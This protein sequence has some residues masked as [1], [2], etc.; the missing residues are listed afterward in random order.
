MN[1][2]TQARI[3]S[4]AI[5]RRTFLSASTA[6]AAASAGAQQPAIPIIDTHIHF[7]DTT[8]PIGVPY[9]GRNAAPGLPVAIPE[10]FRRVAVPLGVVGAI[11]LEASPWIEDNLWVLELCRK[12]T[13]MLG[14]V[15]NLEPEK[16]EF[17]EYLARYHKD[18][19]FLGIR[20]GN[21]WGRNIVSQ[22]ENPEFVAGIK[23]LAAAGLTMDTA[24]PRPDLIRA[25]VRLTDKVPDLRVV[26]DHLPGLEP[27]AE[28]AS[29]RAF[30]T[31]L[32]ELAKRKVFVKVSV[33]ARLVDGKVPTDLAIYKPRLDL[34]WDIF[35]EDRL[36]YASDWPN[37]AGN[38][39]P[40]AT[41]LALVR[42]FFMGKGRGAAEK[43]FWKNSIA[44][45]KWVRRAANQPRLP[46][47]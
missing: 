13:M 45:Y 44:A 1:Q 12:D 16:P 27:P 30:E 3:T 32:R 41:E 26:V 43:Y 37:S 40:Y 7:Y 39:V 14:T 15:G 33:V 10:T 36:L 38:W 47:A 18:P 34:I 22:V 46:A 11:E 23:D 20:C 24:N 2:H 25:I 9:P 42:E 19:L 28:P 29:R 8:R 6:L 17:R 35:G 4:G 21:I 31:D 5:S